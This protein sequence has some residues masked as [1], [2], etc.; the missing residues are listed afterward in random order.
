MFPAR[1]FPASVPALA[2]LLF[3]AAT[4]SAQTPPA[5]QSALDLGHEVLAATLDP[6]E[7]Y[8]VRE[9][10]LHEDDANFYLTDGYLIFGKPVNGAPVSAVFSADL[11][12]G[13]AEL[14][15]IP[16]DRA[17]RRTL[18]AFTSAPNLDEHFSQAV[19]FFTDP[20]A[21]A[22][23]AQIRSDPSAEKVPAYGRLIAEKWGVTVTSLMSSFDTRIVLDLL[24]PP[25]TPADYAHGFFEA[26]LRGRKLGEFDVI[27]DSRATE[28]IAAGKLSTRDG[29]PNW[30]TWT[31]FPASRR[32]DYPPPAAEQEILS[33]KIDA[34]LDSSLSMRA[35]TQMRIRTTAASRA[36]IP[37]ELTAEMRVISAKVDG[38]PAELYQRQSLRSGLVGDF[39]NELLL[40]VPAQP[41]EP[42]TEHDVAIVH[43]GKVVHE[44]GNKIYYVSSRGTWYPGRGFQFADYDVTFHYPDNF[45]LVSAGAVIEDRT[46]NGIHTTR[47]V[48]EGKLRLL[49]FNLGQYTKRDAQK[50]G[51]SLEVFANPEFEEELRPALP[52]LQLDPNPPAAVPAA[53]HAIRLPQ[54]S[55]PAPEPAQPADRIDALSTELISALRFFQSRFGDPPLKHIAV[56]P[57]P[58]RFGQGF[59]G[60][61]YLPT[62]MYVNP[63]GLTPRITPAQFDQAF[64]GQLLRAHE[65]AHQW[66]GNTVTTD[67][68]HHEWLMESLA[69][70]SAI[71]FLESTQG[72]KAVEQAL[73]L[74]RDELAAKGPDGLT[75]ESRGPV[76]E[77]RR[78]ESFSVPGAANAVLYG[79]GTWI[80]HMLR[81]RLGDAPFLKMLAELRRRYE[82][83]TITTDQ[84]RALCA[85]F[86]PPGASDP[87]LT[88][89]FD[90]WVYDTGMPTLKLTYT[91]VGRKLTGTITQTDAPADFSV[92]VP[93]EIKTG[94][95]KT[96]TKVVRTSSDPVKF[97]AEVAGPGA[98]AT[99]DPA[100][101]VL[102][103]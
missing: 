12:G 48:P 88:D 40:V 69:N 23:A 51:I 90:L 27:D 15:L 44:A 59:A 83:Q 58:G 9:I 37:F 91:V 6:D 95:G 78:L 28:Q 4:L 11:E 81:R 79:K 101:S 10:Q 20:A 57:V 29:I 17:E 60:M 67:S 33:Y 1:R 36:A 47:R 72:P 70:Y 50:N 97:T 32:K 19:F 77:G 89:F 45:T 34:T 63:A 102:H 16:P 56:S 38:I 65:A 96:I 73:S 76:V 3:C 25:A 52:P 18:A 98:K 71:L 5:R 64:M 41:L 99:L 14:V 93:I 2:F 61:I 43:E 30:E 87:N 24:S 54:I 85:S 80:I 49:G 82:W 55:A 74:Y 46:A 26:A 86:L 62:L 39:G 84:F 13:D 100:W 8:H 21:R 53:S 92:P 75:A 42:G 66:W 31:R 68:Y 103:R 35:V 22:L 7:C 94:T